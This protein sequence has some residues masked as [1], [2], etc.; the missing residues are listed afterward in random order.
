MDLSDVGSVIT[1]AGTDL[2]PY[3]THAG[4][5]RLLTGAGVPS[6][7]SLLGFGPLCERPALRR[8]AELVDDAEK[9]A[10]ELRDQ[11]VIGA[12][13]TVDRDLESLVLNGA[14]GEVSTTYVHPRRPGLMG[15]SPLAP[16]LEVLLRFAAVTDEL[17]TSRGRFASHGYGAK[18]VAQASE[19]L[20]SVFAEDAGDDPA[21]YWRMAALIRPLARIA[22]PGTGLALDLPSRLLDEEFGSASIVRFE[23]V[24]FPGKLTHEPTRRFL[25]EVGL[26]ENGYWYELDT[27]VLR[28]RPWPSTTRTRTAAPRTNSRPRPTG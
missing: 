7:S 9:L 13:R 12:L 23:D 24:D 25:R 26:P 5:R 16:S 17:V 14:T 27:D 20:A 6:G 10:E 1:L 2:D 28:C 11:L 4:T 8:V 22:R 18:A 15:L 3:I 21:P 19:R